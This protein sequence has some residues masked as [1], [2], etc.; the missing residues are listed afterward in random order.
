MSLSRAE[1]LR[2][3]VVGALATVAHWLT[4]A[5]LVE[6]A[7]W[8]AWTASGAGAALGAQ[9]AFAGNRSFTFAGAR[10]LPLL[11]SWWRFQ[12]TAAA[13]GALGMAI[14]AA[15]VALG[16][17]YLLA[18]VLATG[19]VFVCGYLVNRHWSFRPPA[20]RPGPG[21]RRPPPDPR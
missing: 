15:G 6:A 13:G 5:V 16:V 8:A 9:V 3:A 17:Y 7:G 10:Q 11:A 18:Q 14:V 19:V 12:L 20:R 4:L 1:P 2:Y 21:P